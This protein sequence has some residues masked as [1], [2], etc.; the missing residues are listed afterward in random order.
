MLVGA[1][2]ASLFSAQWY[3]CKRVEDDTS[4]LVCD[5]IIPHLGNPALFWDE[6]CRHSAALSRKNKQREE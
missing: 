5:H 6:C 2:C 3:K 4:I 1:P